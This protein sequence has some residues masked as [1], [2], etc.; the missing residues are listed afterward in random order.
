MGPSTGLLGND[1]YC[2]ALGG[3]TSD[4]V[5]GTNNNWLME[6]SLA[7]RVRATANAVDL[8]CSGA[9]FWKGWKSTDSTVTQTYFDAE[10]DTGDGLNHV[11][12]SAIVDDANG[13]YWQD[14][15]DGA[16][17]GKQTDRGEWVYNCCMNSEVLSGFVHCMNFISSEFVDAA[18]FNYVAAFNETW[19]DTAT[20]TEQESCEKMHKLGLG[21]LSGD[22]LDNWNMMCQ[23]SEMRGRLKALWNTV[24]AA[25]AGTMTPD[26]F[27]TTYQEYWG[28]AESV[29]SDDFDNISDNLYGNMNACANLKPTTTGTPAVASSCTTAGNWSDFSEVQTVLLNDAALDLLSVSASATDACYIN[30][31]VLG[32]NTS[33][34]YYCCLNSSN[35]AG[36][37]SC[38]R[39]AFGSGSLMT[40]AANTNDDGTDAALSS[41]YTASTTDKL[42][43]DNVK[44]LWNAGNGV[45]NWVNTSWAAFSL[46]STAVSGTLGFLSQMRFY[47]VS[48]L[49]SND[50]SWYADNSANLFNTASMLDTTETANIATARA[51]EMANYRTKLAAQPKAFLRNYG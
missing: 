33:D 26:L 50:N 4:G 41:T 27:D 11:D 21:W 48:C 19:G 22:Q 30:T 7:S 25:E 31:G 24:G 6:S 32:A 12:D 9:S 16:C 47:E 37:G 42:G 51:A 39:T 10:K 1:A 34:A 29:D 15:T 36:F 5:G 3:K 46:D 45:T 20:D 13:L 17:G 49:M 23:S 8:D 35:A 14:G 2:T 43:Y 28:N 38:V 40:T 18:G 44:T